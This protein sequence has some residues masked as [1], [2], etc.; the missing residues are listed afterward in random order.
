MKLNRR[1]LMKLRQQL[2]DKNKL[3]RQNAMFGR[4]RTINEFRLVINNIEHNEEELKI[5]TKLLDWYN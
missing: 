5:I 1:N 2:E 4:Y 3:I